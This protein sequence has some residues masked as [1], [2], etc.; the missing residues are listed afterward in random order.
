MNIINNHFFNL[1][2]I[3][4]IQCLKEKF[5]NIFLRSPIKD[6]FESNTID[7][8]SKGS[9]PSNVLSN[10]H[11]SKFTLDGIQINSMEGFLQSLKTSDIN[12]QNKICQLTGKFAKQAGEDLAL[13]F[14]HKT[15]FWQG[16]IIDRFSEDYDNLLQRAYRAKFDQDLLF[17]SALEAT[18]DKTL[19]HS[20][21]KHS[22]EETILTEEEFI[23]LLNHLRNQL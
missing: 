2:K 17:R 4:K 18:K 15:V 12:L 21:G 1:K 10:F 7:I 22:K 8:H 13:Q 3:N 6:I 14:D 16:K 19:I 23:N 9:F 20:I 11:E 5:S